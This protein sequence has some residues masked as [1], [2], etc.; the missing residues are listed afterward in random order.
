M[1]GLGVGS[2]K[3]NEVLGVLAER[4]EWRFGRAKRGCFERDGAE[5][6]REEEGKKKQEKL[7]G[8]RNLTGRGRGVDR[9]NGGFA[10]TFFAGRLWRRGPA[11]G[12]RGNRGSVGTA[13]NSGLGFPPALRRRRGFCAAEPPTLR[14][15]QRRL[16]APGRVILLRVN[17]ATK[18]GAVI[19]KGCYELLR[20]A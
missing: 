18:E 5:G 3:E 2:R 12:C 16:E 7:A 8:G 10:A 15:R 14:W 19:S 20:I 13:W 17:V 6:E 9:D 4:Q 1:D 11:L